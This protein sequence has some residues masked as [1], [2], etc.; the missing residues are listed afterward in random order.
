MVNKILKSILRKFGFELFRLPNSNKRNLFKLLNAYNINL[1]FDV[2]AN[3]GQYANEVFQLG[4]K[5]KIVSFEP[6][7]LVFETLKINKK[8]N[9]NWIVENFAI[10][11]KNGTTNI[12][13]SKNHES[14]SILQ[15]KKLH[16]VNAP[17][18]EVLTTEEIAIYKLDYIYNRYISHNSNILLKIDSQGYED[19]ILD[20]AKEFLNKVVGVQIEMSLVELYDGQMLFENMYKKMSDMGYVLMHV[21]PSFVSPKTGQLLQFDGLF[22]KSKL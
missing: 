6:I 14:S 19:L 9:H 11:N 7:K 22:F 5:G 2:G 13:V 21:T 16:V 17:D 20:G 18:S 10:G 8:L 3:T 15:I 12:N 4:Y 1:I